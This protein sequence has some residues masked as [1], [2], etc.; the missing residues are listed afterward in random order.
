MIEAKIKAIAPW[1]GGKRTMAP[2]ICTEL[3]KHASYFG[4]CCGSLA[5]EFAKEPAR[6]ETVVDMHWHV[7]NLARVL[8]H[9]ELALRLYERSLKT[10]CSDRLYYAAQEYIENSDMLESEEPD[11]EAAY[12]Y[13]VFSWQGR[14]GTAGTVRTNYA[15]SVRFT[16]GGGSSSK[17][18]QSAAESIPAWHQ[19]LLNMTIL[20]RN[21]FDVL[22]RLNDEK[23]LAIYADPPYLRDTRANGG[24]SRYL[25]EF[26]E[27][28]QPLLGEGDDHARLH[29]ELSRFRQARVVVSYYDHPRIRQLYRGW[30]IV[31]HTSQKNLHVQNRRGEGSCEAPEILIINGPSLVKGSPAKSAR[32]KKVTTRK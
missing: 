24:G 30:T 23:A 9:E 13:L 19:R 10:M 1:F 7:T 5:V 32:K 18:W 22:P 3:G 16:A 20:T 11:F 12:Q 31:E 15:P 28:D 27:S 21:V 25:F 2:A 17:R 26:S 8:Q 14:N 29:A 6:Q 4:V